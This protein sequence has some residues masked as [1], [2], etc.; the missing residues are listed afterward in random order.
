[1]HGDLQ[2]KKSL[3]ALAALSTIAGVAQAQSSV[4]LYGTMDASVGYIQN[5]GGIPLKADGT[6]SIPLVG[7]S[8]AATSNNSTT[9]LNQ[10]TT[11]N[12]AYAGIVQPG[13]Y[14]NTNMAGLFDGAV[15]SSVWGIKGSEDLGGGT[16]V[17]FQAEGDL[18]TVNGAYNPS[19]LF[20]RGTFVGMQGSFGEITLGLRGNQFVAASSEAIVVSNNSVM[21]NVKT[22]MGY[23]DDY[24][25]NG[26]TYISPVIAGSTAI[27][28]YGATNTA[29]DISSGSVLN[30]AFRTTQGAFSAIAAFQLR[31]SVA[32]STFNVAQNL[33]GG[34]SSVGN[35][36]AVGVPI[37]P[38]T[39]TNV[40]EANTSGTKTTYLAGLKY[41]V[42]P[43]IK[44][45]Y[46]YIN[47]NY[48]PAGAGVPALASTATALAT[49][50]AGKYIIAANVFSL[51]YQATPNLLLGAAYV[52]TTQ[53]S[54]MS[55]L[56]A[57]YS[58][59]KRST[60]YA[61]VAYVQN[62]A[63]VDSNGNANGNMAPIFT[64]TSDVAMAGTAGNAMNSA[65]TSSG[66]VGLPQTNITAINVGMVHTF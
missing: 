44:L 31:N 53:D 25:K 56:I 51:G 45:G 11:V 63:G 12:N 42:T 49:V 38:A 48:D 54:K 35:T 61:Q 22:A 17:I 65:S 60:A 10:A 50:T 21:L 36:T 24:T 59:S 55:N 29:G 2:M 15:A 16:K 3:L 46:T 62:G 39:L 9:A 37:L 34:S 40:T 6:P 28:Q 32:G 13:G 26:I 52:V 64:Q 30:G 23:G 58:L 8:T 41:Q 7:T 1:M 27:L 47:N 57:K 43:S 20:R 18:N 4:T 14:S 33:A 5:A 19:G 66:Y